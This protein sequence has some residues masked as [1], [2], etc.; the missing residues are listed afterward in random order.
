MAGE[1]QV[2]MMTGVGV[3]DNLWEPGLE[4]SLRDLGFYLRT[5]KGF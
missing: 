3:G 1:I 4:R 2:V 5:G